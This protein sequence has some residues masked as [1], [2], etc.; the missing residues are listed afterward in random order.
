MTRLVKHTATSPAKVTTPSGDDVWVCRCGLTTSE[1]GTCSSKHK[2][3]KGEEE[4]KLYC[5]NAD[6]ERHECE[7]CEN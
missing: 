3:T 1:D 5:Y 2:H 7:G 6:F 4:G